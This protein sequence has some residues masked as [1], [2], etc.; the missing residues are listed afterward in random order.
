[1][2]LSKRLVDYKIAGRQ[3]MKFRFA[4]SVGLAAA[5]V[6]SIFVML[7]FESPTS[8]NSNEVNSVTGSV[9]S[10]NSDQGLRSR[11]FDLGSSQIS[12]QPTLGLAAQSGSGLDATAIEPVYVYPDGS[13]APNPGDASVSPS[14]SGDFDDDD[15]DSDHHEG[16]DDHEDHDDDDDHYR[17]EDAMW[18]ELVRG[19][20]GESDER[21]ELGEAH[22]D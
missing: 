18:S 13:V 22:D 1:M 12:G 20:F 21:H 14:Y 11:S 8:A 6:M 5:V 15:R 19:W 7:R 4:L 9:S 3:I 2:I 10:A 16:Y 17:D